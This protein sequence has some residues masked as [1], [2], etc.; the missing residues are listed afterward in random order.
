MTHEKKHFICTKV[1]KSR[2]FQNVFEWGDSNLHE[3]FMR[4]RFDRTPRSR[5]VMKAGKNINYSNVLAKTVNLKSSYDTP[6]RKRNSIPT[7]DRGLGEPG[8]S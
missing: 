6:S 4:I 5:S 2:S 8:F 1:F 7:E 3:R